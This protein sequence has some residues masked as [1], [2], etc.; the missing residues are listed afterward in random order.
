MTQSCRRGWAQGGLS[1]HWTEVLSSGLSKSISAD[2]H[3]WH[4]P[5]TTPSI[6]RSSSSP[7]TCPGVPVAEPEAILRTI[8]P[9]GRRALAVSKLEWLY[10][11]SLRWN[12]RM[13]LRSAKS[14]SA[15]V[16]QPT[17]SVWCLLPLHLPPPA[18]A[19]GPN[20]PQ[21]LNEIENQLDFS[22]CKQK[23]GNRSQKG[24]FSTWNGTLICQEL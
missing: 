7:L 3:V 10:R 5:P 11:E 20:C 17:T 9:T 12:A 13:L 18:P 14:A 1:S 24:I 19:A 15:P 21:H 22:L 8:P 16:L 2:V 6:S 4:V 23:D